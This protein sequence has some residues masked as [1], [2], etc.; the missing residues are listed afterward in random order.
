[1]VFLTYA[2]QTYSKCTNIHSFRDW[3]I[4]DYLSATG[5]VDVCDVPSKHDIMYLTK[6]VLIAERR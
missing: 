5:I 6:V 4:N 1:V 2:S 3:L